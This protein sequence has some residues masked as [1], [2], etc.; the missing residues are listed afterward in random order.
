MVCHPAGG[1]GRQQQER[2]PPP[3]PR[4]A[5]S[6]NEGFEFRRLSAA[7]GIRA[8]Q[9]VKRTITQFVLLSLG[10]G[11]NGKTAP[12]LV[13]EKQGCGPHPELNINCSRSAYRA[14]HKAGCTNFGELGLSWL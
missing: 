9:E 3:A 1:V 14:E 12:P 11:G 7:I 10:G 8:R 2:L 6:Q 13:R 5:R 4:P